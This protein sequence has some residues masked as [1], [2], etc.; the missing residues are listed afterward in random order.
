M[1]GAGDTFGASLALQLGAGADAAAAAIAA[2]ERVV[3][4]LDAR[5]RARSQ[6]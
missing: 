2:T 5:R 3:R 4:M 1:V 6:P